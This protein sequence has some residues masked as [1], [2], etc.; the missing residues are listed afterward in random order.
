MGLPPVFPAGSIIQTTVPPAVFL[1]PKRASQH[2]ATI[3]RSG[4]SPYLAGLILRRVRLTKNAALARTTGLDPS[5]KIRGLMANTKGTV[6]VGTFD[7]L[8][9]GLDANT[10][11][12][13]STDADL[14]LDVAAGSVFQAEITQ[15]G[16]SKVSMRDAT[17][18]FD[19]SLG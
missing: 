19:L 15:R 13:I 10:P 12:L 11:R 18:L 17:V 7:S 9:G 5:V 14:N 8:L 16:W 3:V 1:T 2:V 4:A 6:E